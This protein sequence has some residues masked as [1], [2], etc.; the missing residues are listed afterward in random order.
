MQLE[1]F[2]VHVQKSFLDPSEILSKACTTRW[3][4]SLVVS[5]G[6]MN[7]TIDLFIL[8]LQY[9][10]EQSLGMDPQQILRSNCNVQLILL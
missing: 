2:S 6:P 9:P 4:P 3:R 7:Q 10:W 8:G 1:M 5:G